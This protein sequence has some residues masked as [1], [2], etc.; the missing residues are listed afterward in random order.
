MTLRSASRRPDLAHRLEVHQRPLVDLELAQLRRLGREHVAQRAEALQ[1]R[2]GQRLGVDPL[3]R[4]E[5]QQ[6]Q[7]LVV[8]Q[9]LDA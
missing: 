4:I 5:Q 7:Q 2:L 3:D 6:L 9:R 8:G 1:Q